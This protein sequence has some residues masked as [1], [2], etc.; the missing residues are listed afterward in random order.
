MTTP[1]NEDKGILREWTPLTSLL[2]KL[3][4]KMQN[5]LFFQDLN[6]TCIDAVPEFIAIG[7]NHGMIYWYNRETG[8][9]QKL[10]CEVSVLF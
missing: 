2:Q 7:T 6:I 9:L 3:P 10:K 8:E 1:I 5:G 4:S